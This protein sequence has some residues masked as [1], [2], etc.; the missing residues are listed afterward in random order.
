M[1]S[2]GKP[3]NLKAGKPQ[4]PSLSLPEGAPVT[5]PL[6]GPRRF[7]APIGLASLDAAVTGAGPRNAGT[8]GSW[9]G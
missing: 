6:E 5:T 1:G 9:R 2:A 8:I 7:G 3:G 4:P